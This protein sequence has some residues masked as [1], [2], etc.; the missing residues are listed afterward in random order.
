[1]DFA[2]RVGVICFAASYAVGLAF[3][4]LRLFVPHRWVRWLAT[5][6]AVAGL[7]A[8]SLFLAAIAVQHHRPPI[9]TQFESLITVSWLVGL[10]YLYLL[11][12]DRRLGAG[13]FLLPVILVL[14]LFAG[15][16]TDQIGRAHV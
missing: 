16:I 5:G 4:L 2:S 9:E 7:F 8:Q 12:R 10:V 6:A 11:L 15:S 14:V 13:L 1:M 3:E